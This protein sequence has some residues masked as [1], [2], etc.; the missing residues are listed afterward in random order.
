MSVAVEGYRTVVHWLTRKLAV[1]LLPAHA[2]VGF[3]SLAT[4]FLLQYLSSILS[5]RIFSHVPARSRKDWDVHV[6]A[7]VHAVWATSVAIWILSSPVGE[8]LAR[9]KVFAY[10]MTAGNIF[11]VSLG[12]FS[13]DT[14]RCLDTRGFGLY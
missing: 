2:D 3:A 4:C 12:Y 8:R 5:P 1:P 7:F 10:D 14:V 9:D 11:A 13:W 6:V